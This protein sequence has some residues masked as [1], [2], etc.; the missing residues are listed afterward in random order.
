MSDYSVDLLYETLTFQ[1][2]EAIICFLCV[3]KMEP[4][5]RNRELFSDIPL[6]NSILD[7][8]LRF[9]QNQNIQRQS[10]Y[11]L[12]YFSRSGVETQILLHS[13]G[14]VLKHIISCLCSDSSVVS[15]FIYVLDVMLRR[16][17][18]NSSDSDDRSSISAVSNTKVVA[19]V[20]EV[21]KHELDLA[22]IG[23]LASNCVGPEV[24]FGN[25]IS[26]LH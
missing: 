21:R 23:L 3:D 24:I 22:L 13:S 11:I 4:Y 14:R 26:F 1:T 12:C 17:K 8:T 5:L 15:Q 16:G 19:D 18:K 25:I 6:S 7:V 9:T 20:A 2:L 10:M